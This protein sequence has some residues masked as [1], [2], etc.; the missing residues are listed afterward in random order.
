MNLLN[1]LQQCQ[2]FGAQHFTI[3]FFIL[4]SLIQIAPIKFNPWST[5]GKVLLGDL[6][7]KINNME[8]KI[9]NIEYKEDRRD[10][11]NKRVRILRFEDELQ[12]TRYH[13]K[14]SFDQV[15]SD[16]TDYNIYCKQHPQ[17]KNEQTMATVEHI[18]KVYKKRLQKH[19]FL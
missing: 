7:N 9:D 10:A 5:I 16:I 2:N 18:T 1:I 15:L 19:D 3:I 13:S 4:L 12:D 17:F 14:D 6:T 8:K 11:I